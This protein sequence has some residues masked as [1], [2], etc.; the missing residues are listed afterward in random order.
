MK[1]GKKIDKEPLVVIALYAV[2]FAV[3]YFG[4]YGFDRDAENYKYILGMPE[5]F[6]YSCIVGYVGICILLYLCLKF[7]CKDEEEK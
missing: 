7:F 3:W 6:F 2:F 1:K 5:W 4:A